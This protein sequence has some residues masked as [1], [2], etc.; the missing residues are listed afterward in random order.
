MLKQSLLS[1]TTR[2]FAEQFQTHPQWAYSHHMFTTWGLHWN[3]TPDSLCDLTRSFHYLQHDFKTLPSL[4]FTQHITS[5]MIKRYINLR[6]IIT[7]EMFR[8]LKRHTVPLCMYL[9]RHT[10][11]LCMYLKRHTVPLCM[12]LKRHTVPLCMYLKR[13]TVPLYGPCTMRTV[14]PIKPM[15]RRSSPRP[16]PLPAAATPPALLGWA[17]LDRRGDIGT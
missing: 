5:F 11:P 2:L 7:Y 16:R 14:W 8:W 1:C 15:L 13:H 6:L 9:K 3:S 4:W 12:Y 10:V 17:G